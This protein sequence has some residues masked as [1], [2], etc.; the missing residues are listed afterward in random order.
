MR[1]HVNKDHADGLRRKSAVVDEQIMFESESIFCPICRNL[2]RK[3]KS[4]QPWVHDS[5]REATQPP[6]E[7]VEQGGV[8][9]EGD[10]G[11]TVT[12]SFVEWMQE[13]SNEIKEFKAAGLRGD[14]VGQQWRMHNI[15]T[16]G[17]KPQAKLNV[18]VVSDP[19]DEEEFNSLLE[20]ARDQAAARANADAD[21]Q[22]EVEKASVERILR[23]VK[24]LEKGEISEARRA[25]TQKTGL[26]EPTLISIQ[27]LKR[28][29]FPPARPEADNIHTPNPTPPVQVVKFDIEE[30][31]RYLQPR[32][33]RSPDA[34]G[35]HARGLLAV[36]NESDDNARA[37]LDMLSMIMGGTGSITEDPLVDALLTFLGHCIPKGKDGVSIRPA[38]SP[39]LFLQMAISIVLR[40]NVDKQ[41]ALIGEGQVGT[42][43]SAGGEAYARAAQLDYEYHTEKKTDDYCMLVLDVKGFYDKID[44][45]ACRNAGNSLEPIAAVA[46]LI[47]GRRNPT[48]C[49][50]N[51]TTNTE[52]KLEAQNGTIQGLSV[53]G[54]CASKAMNDVATHVRASHLQVSMPNFHD[55]GRI[56]GPFDAVFNAFDAFVGAIQTKLGL[57]INF[58]DGLGILPVDPLCITTERAGMLQER[59]IP[60]LEGIMQSGI[61]V[62]P[63][64]WIQK[65]LDEV[66]ESVRTDASEI[67]GVVGKHDKLTRKALTSVIRLTTTAAFTHLIRGAAPSAT[68]EAAKRVDRIAV[69]ATLSA[70][71][72]GHIDPRTPRVSE[73][74]LLSTECGGAGVGSLALAKDAAY[75][76]SFAT[77]QKVVR[78]LVHKDTRFLPSLPMV[79]ELGAALARVKAKCRG[80]AKDK[81]ADEMAV[82]ALT[83]E[84]ILNPGENAH[85]FANLQSTITAMLNRAQRERIIEDLKAEGKDSDM[86]SFISCGGRKAGNWVVSSVKGQGT[87]MDNMQFTVALSL[88]LGVEAFADIKPGHK[89]GLCGKAIGTSATHGALCTVGGAGTS[90][91]N[92][93]HYAL[94]AEIA[95]ILKWL[96]PT[97]RVKFEPEIVRHFHKQPKNWK[98]DRFRR[99]DLW[100]RTAKESYI[101]DTSIGLAA[102][103]AHT[104]LFS[105]DTR[106]GAVARKLAK[107]KVLQYI[108][109]F[110]NFK[111]HEIIAACAEAEGTLDV[112]FLDFLKR[113]IDEACDSNPALIKQRVATEVYERLSVAIQR[114]NADGVISWRYSEFG[115]SLHDS[116]SDPV[117]AAL[118]SAPIN[119]AECDRDLRRGQGAEAVAVAEEGAEEAVAV[120][121]AGAGAEEAAAAEA[122]TGGSGAALYGTVPPHETGGFSRPEAGAGGVP[123][124]D[125]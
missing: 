36:I 69:A 109:A 26:R 7:G 42:A 67:A 85:T 51:K 40:R 33:A 80:V 20:E 96:D 124:A 63:R 99:G 52:Y 49:Y 34:W 107:D 29:Y 46:G 28:T 9:G 32:L 121:V 97:T 102:A 123:A 108:S 88:R 79:K 56:D 83:T 21:A 13:T 98:E 73:R 117:F 104:S 64:S 11:E 8:E 37:I 23:I 2:F 50:R 103:A 78:T 62:G 125:N 95:R 91:R 61:P 66:V 58:K 110:T 54:F 10:E 24:H 86:R 120:A 15:I 53:S 27:Q 4:G 68:E 81:S 100:I 39:C 60:V 94:N 3:T 59:G 5:C 57:T 47:Y 119:L 116:D 113:R 70:G 12:K 72:L 31:R 92:E 122:D 101:I 45:A 84:G 14:T 112:F 77:T 105:K 6:A 41:R 48:V 75:I 18:Q 93:R 82:M 87:N 25:I 76:A 44:K 74:A 43:V 89:C 1:Q 71:G 16:R 115:S 55:D 111:Q 118:N 35:W 19:E 65:K 22:G 17:P 114:A 106:A 90:T 38:C 30:V